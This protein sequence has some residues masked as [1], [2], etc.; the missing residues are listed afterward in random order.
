M[1]HTVSERAFRCPVCGTVIK[2]YKKTNRMTAIGHVKTMW[3]YKCKNVENF[4]Q[5][6]CY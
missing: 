3:C 2:A 5:I 1:K 6:Q 4:T